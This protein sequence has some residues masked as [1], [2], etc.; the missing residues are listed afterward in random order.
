M[1]SSPEAGNWKVGMTEPDD[2]EFKNEIEEIGARID[3][4]LQNIA[5]YSQKPPPKVEVQD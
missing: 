2:A 5:R 1:G 3:A 4:I